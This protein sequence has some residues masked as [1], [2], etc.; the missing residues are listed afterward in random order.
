M[1]S[2]FAFTIVGIVT[3]SIF[4]VAASG[5]VVT[6]TASG[7]FNIAHGAIGMLMAFVYWQLRVGWHWPAPLAL[8][9]VL[10]VAAPL[11]GAGV[12]R[13]LIRKVQGK[14]VVT[15]L[16]VTIGLMVGLIGVV[17]TVWKPETRV[18]QGFFGGNGFSVGSV[19]VTWHQAITVVVA[20]AIAVALR[21]FLFRTRTGVA[22]RAVVDDPN[23]AGLNGAR[24]ARRSSLSWALGSSLAALAGI[25]IAPAL[26]LAVLPLTLL[27]VDA[28]AAAMVGRLRNLPLTFAGALGLGLAESYAVGY[29]PN[30]LV[31]NSAVLQGLRLSIPTLMLF[32]TLLL[33]P[34]AKLRAGRAMV[35]RRSLTIPTLRR[36]LY[37][38]LVLVV[39]VWVAA[40][41]L[42]AGN[43]SRL[44]AGLAFALIMLSLVPL[45]GYGGQVSLCQMTFAG[46]GAFAMVKLG[47]GGS[48]LG[49]MAAAALAAGVCAL[50]ALPSLRLQGLYLALSTMA[51]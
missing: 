50:I 19:F 23:L 1:T 13:F 41:A 30:S 31:R 9:M 18:L 32:A 28:Y 10:L 45:S 16:V 46:L 3:G 43:L 7:V 20:I 22:M 4:A 47:A 12:E 38:G 8:A 51:F 5:L 17:Q 2:F 48:P 42:S 6:Y 15:S 44:G 35:Q 11:F 37:A 36:S 40:G 33:L 39:V 29:L 14:S 27:V 34:Q 26:Q 49:L 21:L 24:P 25:L